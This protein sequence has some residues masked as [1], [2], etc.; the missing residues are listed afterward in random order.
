MKRVLGWLLSPLFFSD[1]ASS[2]F[3]QTFCLS[4]KSRKVKSFT[5][6]NL[7]SKRLGY[8]ARP[9]HTKGE[10]LIVYLYLTKLFLAVRT[11]FTVSETWHRFQRIISPK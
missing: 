5:A 3:W 1:F 8:R 7:G 6:N 2:K 10:Y 4:N 11:K 9:E